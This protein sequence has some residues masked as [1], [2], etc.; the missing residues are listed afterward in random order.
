[1]EE[2][3][4]EEDSIEDIGQVREIGEVSRIVE[5]SLSGGWHR[6]FND[7]GDSI[8]PVLLLTDNNSLYFES[9]YRLGDKAG[10]I[11]LFN[12]VDN[13]D[14]AAYSTNNYIENA[15]NSDNGPKDQ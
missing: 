4:I 10:S 5:V 15:S 7:G 6:A 8:Q 14:Q 9:P 1:M 12:K 13:I 3:S 2:D 11:Q